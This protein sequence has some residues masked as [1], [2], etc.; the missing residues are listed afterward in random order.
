MQPTQVI[1]LLIA[2]GCQLIPDGSQLRVRDP[3]RFLT[4]EVRYYLRRHKTAIL[5]LLCADQPV[6][7]ATKIDA[8]EVPL[9]LSHNSHNSHNSVEGSY[10]A[11]SVKAG[12][13]S[14]RDGEALAEQ[15]LPSPAHDSPPPAHRC[16]ETCPTD[17]LRAQSPWLDGREPFL[18]QGADPVV[19]VKVFSPMLGGNV[20]VI[21]D[22]LPHEEWPTD[23]P[24]YT[25]AEVKILAQVGPDTLAWVHPMKELFGARVVYAKI[26]KEKG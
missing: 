3:Q 6:G 14:P 15:P 26:P 8:C 5:R 2:A 21:D 24:V 10:S 17:G 16:E 4:D 23:A 11:N 13:T 18:L 7:T 22:A 12:D 19:A 9:S 25:H 1:D 20:W